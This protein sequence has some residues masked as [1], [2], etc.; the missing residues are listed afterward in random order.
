MLS[1]ANAGTGLARINPKVSIFLAD[2]SAC[3]K[4]LSPTIFFAIGLPA[5]LPTKYP[6]IAPA[7]RP[8]HTT[9]D[10]F[11][12]P[13]L[14]PASVFVRP[15]GTGRNTSKVKALITTSET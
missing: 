11:A 12:H 15:F 5:N 4:S 13:K 8:S 1:S 9:K 6:K 3:A 10:A 7:L 2:S 14:A